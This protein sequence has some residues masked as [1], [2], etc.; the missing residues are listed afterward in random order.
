MRGCID[1]RRPNERICY[2]HF[3]MEGLHTIQQ[4][5][6]RND[7]I[8]KVDLGDFHMHLLIG[9]AD[10]RYMRFMWEGRQFRCNGINDPHPIGQILG[11]TGKQQQDAVQSASRQDSIVD[12]LKNPLSLSLKTRSA[13]SQF[14]NF[15]ACSA[16]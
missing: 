1:L 15:A 4:L 8:T 16:S 10:R 6:C 2:K 5:L 9:Q 11:H 12:L 3:K 14:G 13:S 7:Y